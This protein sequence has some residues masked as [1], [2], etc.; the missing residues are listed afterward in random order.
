ML[1]W[2]PHVWEFLDCLH[3]RCQELVLT[4][5]ADGDTWTKVFCTLL[6]QLGIVS[7]FCWNGQMVPFLLRWRPREVHLWGEWRIGGILKWV[8]PW[9][10]GDIRRRR[11]KVGWQLSKAFVWMSY[12]LSAREDLEMGGWFEWIWFC[13][14]GVLLSLEL[15]WAVER[16]MM[17]V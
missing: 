1:A 6:M 8:G 13:Q 17:I 3:R 15:C 5:L 4:A 12:I 2:A 14:H 7:L 9:F 11:L 16:S 10:W